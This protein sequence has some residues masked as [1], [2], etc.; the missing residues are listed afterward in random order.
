MVVTGFLRILELQ[1]CRIYTVP[2]GSAREVSAGV[3]VCGR[4]SSHSS[5]LKSPFRHFVGP[6]AAKWRAKRRRLSFSICREIVV[7][8]G[9][10]GYLNMDQKSV[11][12]ILQDDDGEIATEKL[13]PIVYAEL[14]KLATAQMARETPGQTLQPTALVHEVYL[15]LVG[16]EDIRWENRGHFFAAAARSMRQILINRANRKKAVRH[17]GP[18]KRLELH[19][20]VLVEEQQPERMLALDDALQRLEQIDERKGQIV[21]LRYFA[22]LSIEDTA[23]VLEVSPATVKREWQ[24]ART[25]LHNEMNKSASDDAGSQK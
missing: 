14:R 1:V 18:R 17:G 22:G 19:D 25:W 7:N 9:D 24:F 3:C 10:F 8:T 12:R 16:D 23:K 13:L 4:D 5:Q 15:R 6:D 11:T 2:D 21:M 20:A